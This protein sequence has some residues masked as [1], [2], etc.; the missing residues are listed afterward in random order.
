MSREN[1]ENH[2]MSGIELFLDVFEHMLLLTLADIHIA[3]IL[4]TLVVFITLQSR[5][6]LVR[7]FVQKS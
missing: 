4:R 7:N 6:T 2:F 5:Y 3:W 1:N